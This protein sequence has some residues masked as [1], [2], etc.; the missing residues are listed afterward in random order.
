MDPGTNPAF[1]SRSLVRSR[2]GAFRASDAGSNPAGSMPI[3]AH[4]DGSS[5]LGAVSELA[6]V[7]T[8][9]E[10]LHGFASL[11]QVSNAPVAVYIVRVGLVRVG[12]T[13]IHASQS[14]PRRFLYERLIR[15]TRPT[16]RSR[17]RKAAVASAHDRHRG[18]TDPFGLAGDR[19]REQF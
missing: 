2:I 9:Q 6:F 8:L 16:P 10:I 18:D 1:R 3:L 11:H 13:F 5:S 4:A 14:A 19:T 12:L 17:F 7:G 15:S